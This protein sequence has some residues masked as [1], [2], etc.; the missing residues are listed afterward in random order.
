MDNRKTGLVFNI[1]RFAVNDGP[2]IRTTVFFKGCPLHCPWC[3]NPESISFC[4][5]LLYREDRCLQCG[6]C[7]QACPHEAI[8][9]NNGQFVT[10]SKLCM[11]CGTCIGFC[12]ADARD[13]IGKEFSVKELLSE[14]EKDVVFYDQSEGGVTFSG[15]EP[16]LQYEFLIEILKSCKENNIHTAVDT[17]GYTTPDSMKEAGAFT[18]L[19]LYDLKTLDTVRH[20]MFTGVSNA[21]II[22]NLIH[23]LDRKKNVIIRI[24]IIPD[25]NDDKKSNFQD[26][27][28]LAHLGLERLVKR[29]KNR[30]KK[31]SSH[32]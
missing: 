30:S 25:L 15:G 5:D 22:E 29:L 3:H 27:L 14:I 9:Q 23:L 18:D 7:A 6:D 4:K 24:P 21:I 12:P 20:Q 31:E 32:A 11:R 28:M 1:Q 16:F 17:S 10:V 8:K 2:G 19:F 13:I 26:E